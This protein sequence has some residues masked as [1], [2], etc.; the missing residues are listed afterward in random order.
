MKVAVVY[1]AYRTPLLLLEQSIASVRE[2]AESAGVSVEVIVADNGGNDANPSNLAGVRFVGNGDNRG[3]G[4]AVN[5]AVRASEAEWV[6]LMN[7]DSTADLRLFSEFERAIVAFP[8][9]AMYGALLRSGGHPQVHAYNLWWSS[10]GLALSKGR[11]VKN[12][13]AVVAT[14][15]PVEVARL[16][17]AG[18]FARNS[19]LRGLGPFD[20]DFFLYGEDVD[21]SLR[22]KMA[23]CRLVLVPQ[24]VIVHD[25]GTS[26]EGSSALVERARTDAHI[27][28]VS[29]YRG[30]GVSLAARMEAV[31]VA[32]IGAFV[33]RSPEARRARIGRLRELRRWGVHR[34]VTPF[35]PHAR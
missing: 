29:R 21:L 19:L 9:S 7:P 16:C 1:V 20:D 2:A 14:A 8:G 3:F 23:G 26:S 11:W 33:A 5:D 28:L 34:T 12:L 22:A 18:L 10:V 17:G 13:D 4:A 32:I 15:D 24:A 6:L 31:A 35:S 30:Y 27:R 25:A